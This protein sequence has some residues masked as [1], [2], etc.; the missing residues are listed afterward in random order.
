M[1]N[2]IRINTSFLAVT[3]L[4]FSC[5][6][7]VW[8]KPADERIAES[9]DDISSK[10]QKELYRQQ[11]KTNQGSLD[12]S[13]QQ[14]LNKMYLSNPNLIQADFRIA[15]AK[16]NQKQV[17][18]DMTPGLTLGIND[19]FNI[20]DLGDAFA[21]P[22]YRIN[23]YLSLGNL[24]DLPKNIYTRKL[25]YIGAELSA[26]NTMRQQV[27][28]LY[29]LFQQ[30]RLL[31]LQKKAIDIEGELVKGIIR[32]EGSEVL[33]MKLNHQKALEA[34]IE[35]EKNWKI[36]VGDFFMAGYDNINLKPEDIPN[37]TY[38]PNDLD[39]TDTNRWGLLQLNLL[40]LEDI[41]EKGRFLA[42]YYRYL[43]RANMSVSAPPIY[44][45]T[46]STGFDPALIR[47]NPSLNWSLDSRG[48]IGRQLDR[49][50]RDTPLKNWRMDKRQREEVKKLL[51][52]KE[53]LTEVQAE[54]EKLRSVMESYKS[55]VGSG[56]VED[57]QKAI[58]VL[59]KL[60]EREVRLTAKEIEICSAFWLID[61]Q[62]WKPITKKWLATRSARSK[63]READKNKTNL[64]TLLKR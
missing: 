33:V 20:G 18:K 9:R 22:T 8:M 21:D 42:T 36:K 2:K 34:W 39:F 7:C 52:G 58:Q 61:E 10:F 6:S 23:S 60:R 43:P 30:Q 62:R 53:A 31:K 47:L 35:S 41:A 26:E 4:C 40:A 25:T 46:S 27:I 54:L 17:W 56:L 57:P 59:R 12:I 50:K 11:H 44:S 14:G 24:L 5:I 16:Y 3:T 37:I 19:S 49:L 55:I 64:R 32:I 51:E 29:H 48:Y 1:N 13:W 28:A 63:V 38:N 15:D 45:N